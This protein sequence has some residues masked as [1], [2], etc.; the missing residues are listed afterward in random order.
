MKRFENRIAVVTG[1]TSG[2]GRRITEALCEEGAKVVFWGRNDEKGAQI[3]EKIK[4]NNG[5]VAYMHVDV[6]FANEIKAAA[7]T[8]KAKYGHVDILICSAGVN[9]YKAGT[10]V[11]TDEDEFDKVIDTNVKGTF[12]CCKYIIPL[13]PK[14]GGSVINFSSAWDTI[15]SAKVP[16]YCASKAAITHMTKQIALDFAPHN[17]RANTISPGTVVTEMVEGVISNTYA[18]LG[19]EKPEDMWEARR[20]AYPIGRLGTVDDVAHLT[21]F[22]A[23]DEASW[24]TGA[25]ILIDGGFTF[26]RSF[27]PPPKK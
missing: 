9:Q 19:F 26:S 25:A 7:E 20:L 8:V 1:G 21:L 3:A 10:I 24:I 17:I 13:M 16:V 12:L 14:E 4:A 18:K 2:L 5:E 23:S 27:A 22:L 15:V 11:E 6:R